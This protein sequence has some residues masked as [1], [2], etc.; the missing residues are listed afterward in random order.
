MDTTE[1]TTVRMNVDLMIEHDASVPPEL[2][3]EFAI[4]FTTNAFNYVR[5]NPVLFDQL[6][7][8]FAGMGD[9][10]DEI[11]EALR[12]HVEGLSTAVAMRRR[13]APR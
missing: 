10:E 3:S 11:A 13:G 1:V 12:E 5:T 2:M 8:S 4:F 7:G 9:E 6:V